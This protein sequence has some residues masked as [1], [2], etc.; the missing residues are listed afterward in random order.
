MTYKLPHLIAMFLGLFYT[1]RGSP[2]PL[3]LLIFRVLTVF[4]ARLPRLKRRGCAERKRL[5]SMPKNF[6]DRRRKTRDEK[7]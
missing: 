4:S 7:L 1:G 5:V 6:R 3:L 2:D